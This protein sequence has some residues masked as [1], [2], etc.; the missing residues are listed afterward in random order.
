MLVAQGGPL[1]ERFPT[2]SDLLFI[3]AVMVI[4][5]VVLRLFRRDEGIRK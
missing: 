1:P 3:A 2:L 4:F 5:A